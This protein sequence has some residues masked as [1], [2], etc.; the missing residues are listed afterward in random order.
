MRARAAWDR[1]RW[2]GVRALLLAVGSCAPNVGSGQVAVR[3][4]PPP[5]KMPALQQFDEASCTR[6]ASGY[7]RVYVE[8][9]QAR[10]YRPEIIG[11]GGAPM[12]VAQL[13]EPPPGVVRQQIIPPPPQVS[14]PLNMND[15]ISYRK[16]SQAQVDHLIEIR[17]N[18][19]KGLRGPAAPLP[20]GSRDDELCK[21]FEPR[22]SQCA[23]LYGPLML[24]GKAAAETYRKCLREGLLEH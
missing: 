2:F 11:Q 1:C 5:G 15:P 13:P 20:S 8:C 7:V 19:P 12:S 10:G 24:F 23:T 3:F 22:I 18:L 14:K 21:A 9:M 17:P 16:F 6:G 4:Y